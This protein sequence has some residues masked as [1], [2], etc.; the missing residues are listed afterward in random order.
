MSFTMSE[1]QSLK[2]V[3][4][5]Q[6]SLKT[7]QLKDE[8]DYKSQLWDCSDVADPSTAIYYQAFCESARVSASIRKEL[9]NL[10]KLQKSVKVMIAERVY[11]NRQINKIPESDN[12]EYGE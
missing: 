8:L 7:D 3:L 5:R 12:S 4:S 11:G 6:I 1:L 2:S 9:N 10:H